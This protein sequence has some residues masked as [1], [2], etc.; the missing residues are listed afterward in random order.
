MKQS[1]N[2]THHPYLSIYLYMDE[3]ESYTIIC[4]GDDQELL[5]WD[6]RI[7]ISQDIANGIEYLH[8][9]V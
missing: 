7:A 8:E 2:T 9:G 1:L 4:L 6:M 3:H 5:T